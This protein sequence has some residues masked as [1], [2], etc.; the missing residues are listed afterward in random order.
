MACST[1]HCVSMTAVRLSPSLGGC[2]H[3]SRLVQVGQVGQVV[4]GLEHG[5]VH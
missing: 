1:V 2:M 5:R 3:T 4:A